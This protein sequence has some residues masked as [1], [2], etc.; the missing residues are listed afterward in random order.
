[1]MDFPWEVVEVDGGCVAMISIT[2][3]KYQ[4]KGEP[5]TNKRRPTARY[6]G[7]RWLA[8]R[9]SYHLNVKSI[10]RNP[11][12]TVKG[13]VLHTCDHGWC[14]EPN[15]LYLGTKKQNSR[16]MVNR[17]PN[18]REIT[19]SNTKRF[20]QK[21]SPS[22]LD[23][24]RKRVSE[25]VK[26]HHAS[27]TEEQKRIANEKRSRRMMEVWASRTKEE[28]LIIGAKQTDGQ[29]RRWRESRGNH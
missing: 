19:S 23:D 4:V 5:I 2:T 27:R 20:F 8:S 6:H 3:R 13:F 9:L 12:S 18:Y 17:F 21:A 24:F 1:M 11:P 14:L 7:K 25:G 26:I 22:V 10:P 29:T 28:K 16:D 15:H